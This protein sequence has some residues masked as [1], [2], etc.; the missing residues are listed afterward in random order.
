LPIEAIG[1]EGQGAFPVFLLRNLSR[2]KGIGFFEDTGFYPDF[3]LWVTEG[4]KQRLVFI[5][6]HGMKLEEHPSRNPKV[7]LHKKLK[8]QET[9]ARKKSKLPTLTLDSFIIS[10]TPYDDLR[11]HHESEWDRAKYAEAHIF[12]G[13]EK[14][15]GQLKAIIG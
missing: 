9:E 11:K 8:T 6:P 15:Y 7:N 10:R 1:I 14:E 2:G 12:F 5:E 4:S 13:D 3:I